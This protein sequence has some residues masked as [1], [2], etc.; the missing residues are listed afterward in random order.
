MIN[1]EQNHSTGSDPNSNRQTAERMLVALD[2]HARYYVMARRI[3][4]AAPQPLQRISPEQ[5]LTFAR[6]QKAVARQVCVVY[7][8]GPFGF[9]L[10]RQLIAEG[11]E[12]LVV[13]AK[14]LDPYCKKVRTD[15]TDVRELLTD[16]D[17]YLHG[18][19]RALRPV[20]IPTPE[21]ELA[22][23]QSRQRDALCR[24]L[25]RQAARGRMLLLQ[26][27][28]HQSNHWW[29]PRHW[30]RLQGRLSPQLVDLLERLRSSIQALQQLIGPLET[31][32]VQ[33]APSRLPRGMG[34]LTFV[35]LLREVC[36]W[37]R[38]QT[39]RQVGGF[40]GLCGGVSQS[41]SVSQQLS[42]T[43]T[44]HRRMRTLLIE[45]AWRLVRYQPQCRLV[46]KWLPQ[47]SVGPKNKRRRKQII[48]AVARQLAIDI[49]KWQ[50]GASTPD[51]L[52]WVMKTN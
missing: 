4:S 14:K 11:I 24:D 43:K 13:A 42:I 26:F 1:N 32:L 3:D 5:F 29:K 37:Q 39:R 8:A 28:H 38:F 31:T 21:Q 19:I 7:E 34:K 50:T 2:T 15:K 10:A 17:R 33:T 46:Q 35:L 25:Q 9:G 36:S 49:W 47:L 16:L 18:N 44:G 30:M 6:K 27:G 45:L 22:R 41:G 12:C 52:G 48:V 23:A 40:T 20:R 51:Q